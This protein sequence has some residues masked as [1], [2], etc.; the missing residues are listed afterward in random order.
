MK[1]YSKLHFVAEL[2]RHGS[3][4]PDFLFDLTEKPEE[5]FPTTLELDEYGQRQHYLIGAEMRRRYIEKEPIISSKYN[6]SEVYLRSSNIKRTHESMESQL[7]GLFPPEQCTYKLKDH[8]QK[9]AVPPFEIKGIKEE[10]KELGE[11]ALPD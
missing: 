5:N 3:R 9:R 2:A 10:V 11:Y 7:I 6:S 4:A 1:V 8:Q